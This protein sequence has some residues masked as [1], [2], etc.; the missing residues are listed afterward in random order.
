M[1]RT[2]KQQL[3]YLKGWNA[4]YEVR[5]KADQRQALIDALLDPTV[6]HEDLIHVLDGW[7]NSQIAHLDSLRGPPTIW[8]RLKELSIVWARFSMM[9]T[10]I[11]LAV[12]YLSLKSN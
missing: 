7:R 10:F 1:P 5:E 6:P 12:W 2:N 4:W 3:A 11:I 8:Q 9:A